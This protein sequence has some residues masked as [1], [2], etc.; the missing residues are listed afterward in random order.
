MTSS[1]ERAWKVNT[2]Y[3]ILCTERFYRFYKDDLDPFRAQFRVGQIANPPVALLRQL[4]PS[5]FLE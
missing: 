5:R 1:P 4:G 2:F 3:T